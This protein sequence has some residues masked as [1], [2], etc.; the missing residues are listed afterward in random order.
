MAVAPVAV[1]AQ[2]LL[3]RRLDP[4]EAQPWLVG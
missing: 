3:Q 4:L 1:G 2:A